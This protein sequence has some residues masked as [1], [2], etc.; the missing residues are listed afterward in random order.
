MGA[1]TGSGG[2]EKRL[3]SGCSKGRANRIFQNNRC[4]TEEK[5]ELKGFQNVSFTH[6]KEWNYQLQD[7]ERRCWGKTD[8]P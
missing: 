2:G 7:C 4:E 5:Q 6:Q 8:L 1:C 3:D